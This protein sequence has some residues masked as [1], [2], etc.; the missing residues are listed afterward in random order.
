MSITFE[1][2]HNKQG[3]V[4]ANPDKEI[5]DLDKALEMIRHAEGNGATMRFIVRA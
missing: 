4:G 1:I 2:W 3:W 5:K